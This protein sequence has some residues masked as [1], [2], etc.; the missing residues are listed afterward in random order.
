MYH[1]LTHSVSMQSVKYVDLVTCWQTFIGVR[2]GRLGG[3]TAAPRVGQ[4]IIFRAEGSRQ[5]WNK[6]FFTK[7]KKTEL[8]PSSK[9]KCPKSGFL[10]IIIVWVGQ[11]L[12][13]NKLYCLQGKQFQVVDIMLFVR[14]RLAVFVRCR[15]IPRAKVAQPPSPRKKL[16]LAP[17]HTLYQFWR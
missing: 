11:K 13:W 9:M 2:T 14:V 8:I 12:F 3:L 17:M 15:N 4:A 1:P 6:V 16:A 7:Q 5:K 10:L